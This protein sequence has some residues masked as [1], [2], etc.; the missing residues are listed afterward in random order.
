VALFFGHPVC[1][2]TKNW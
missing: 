1:Y 2:V